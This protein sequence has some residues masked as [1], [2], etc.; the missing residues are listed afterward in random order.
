M[1]YFAHDDHS[2]SYTST[3]PGPDAGATYTSTADAVSNA[4]TVTVPDSA[5]SC[6]KACIALSCDGTEPERR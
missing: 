2:A 6:S 1:G 3:Q 5:N 4:V